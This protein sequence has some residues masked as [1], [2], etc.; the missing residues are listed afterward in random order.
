MYRRVLKDGAPGLAL[1]VPK[2][3]RAS[4]LSRFHFS[5]GEGAGHAG[6]NTL[7]EL[8]RRDYAWSGMKRECLAFAAACE[9]C[10]GT[11]SQAPIG[12]AAGVA[13]APT[14]HIEHTREMVCIE[15]SIML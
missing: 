12:A 15:S 10:G 6:G 11:R 5:L 4:L 9:Q 7:Y 8:I 3:A 1:E 2:G 14:R 13:P